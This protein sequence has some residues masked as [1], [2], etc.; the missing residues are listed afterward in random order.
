EK[1]NESQSL[2][3]AVNSQ[4]SETDIQQNRSKNLYKDL[5]QLQSQ[6][7]PKSEI[8]ENLQN[9]LSQKLI[10]VESF[11]QTSKNLVKNDEKAKARS[12]CELA[13]KILTDVRK[14]QDSMRM[15][16]PAVSTETLQQTRTE[17]LHN[18]INLLSAQL[19]QAVMVYVESSEDVFGKQ[20]NIVANKLKSQLATNGCSFINDKSKADF[21]LTITVEA[22][23][24]KSINFKLTQFVSCVANIS[25]DIYDLHKQKSVFSDDISEK[26]SATTEEKAAY[27]AMETAVDN[28][29]EKILKV[30]TLGPSSEENINIPNTNFWVSAADESGFFSWEHAQ[31]VCSLKGEGWR[32]P[33]IEELTKMSFVQ[34]EI[35]N[36]NGRN[37]NF[38]YWSSDEKNKKYAYYFD[39]KKREKGR[40]DK[41]DTDKCVRCVKS[42]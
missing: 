37:G 17:N 12:Q 11:L 16:D 2:L 25:L 5:L 27:K 1:I 36:L 39:V 26:G 28:L 30:I 6:L 24:T 13:K 33:T 38:K 35:K 18:E 10:Q 20:V 3:L 19:A 8:L 32:L 42:K 22:K 23:Q 7:D 34:I 4:I 9:N 41:S 14:I 40:D 31:M 29:M 21:K 15:T